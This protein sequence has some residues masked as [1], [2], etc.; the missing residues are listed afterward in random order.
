MFQTFMNIDN[1]SIPGESKDAKHKNWIDVLSFRWDVTGG[2]N[3]R[4]IEKSVSVQSSLFSI[5]KVHDMSSPKLIW[6]VAINKRFDSVKLEVCYKGGDNDGKKLVEYVLTDVII[7]SYNLRA[8][9]VGENR[10]GPPL[11]DIALGYG[12]IRISGYAIDEKN[13]SKLAGEVEIEWKGSQH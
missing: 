3:L 9:T 6:A 1:L 10:T 4:T 13:I 7:A 2:L 5:V 8:E 12:R 11:E